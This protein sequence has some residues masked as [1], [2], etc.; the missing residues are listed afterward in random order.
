[1]SFLQTNPPAATALPVFMF[2][3]APSEAT[4]Q[5]SHKKSREDYEEFARRLGSNGAGVLTEIMRP[6]Y[7][8]RLRIVF[9]GTPHGPL[10]RHATGGRACMPTDE[11]MSPIVWGKNVQVTHRFHH[12]GSDAV[13]GVDAN[14]GI[15]G[16]LMIAQGGVHYGLIGA[17]E[18][19]GAYNPGH[20]A[21]QLAHQKELVVQW[22]KMEAAC[23]RMEQRLIRAGADIML[24]AGD[25]NRPGWT[26]AGYKRISD[27]SKP[28]GAVVL[29][30]YKVVNARYS[31]DG[32]DLST[33]DQHSD[34]DAQ[35]A[36]LRV[37]R[38]ALAA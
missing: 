25:D 1:M 38:K 11:V 6:W 12:H 8:A 37:S 16:T 7:R 31:V 33:Y 19:P 17:H 9:G 27:Q 35:I 4:P 23:Q 26:P 18:P 3:C 10:K 21:A 36:A 20:N 15:V 34:H 13:P 22:Q 28:G 5:L 14:R 2:G 24:R 30:A 32:Y 29:L